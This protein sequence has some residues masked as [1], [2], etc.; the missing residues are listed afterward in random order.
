MQNTHTHT[1]KHPLHL[2]NP[3]VYLCQVIKFNTSFDEKA[4]ARIGTGTPSPLPQISNTELF[5]PE[6]LFNYSNH[7]IW[8]VRTII[9]MVTMDRKDCMTKDL[10]FRHTSLWKTY[11]NKRPVRALNINFSLINR[12]SSKTYLSNSVDTKEASVLVICIKCHY[13]LSNVIDRYPL[14]KLWTVKVM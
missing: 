10:H 9:I 1:Q 11:K 12:H 2:S 13:T 5:R 14:Y 8:G 6:F 4:E 3:W 7:N